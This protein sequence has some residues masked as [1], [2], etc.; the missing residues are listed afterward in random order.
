MFE[1]YECVCLKKD[2]WSTSN[3]KSLQLLESRLS[4]K[5]SQ[6]CFTEEPAYV[7]KLDLLERKLKLT[8]KLLA[9]TRSL[10][11]NAL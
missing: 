9:F 10:V 4:L 11:Q 6:Y 2:L 7:E 3:T 1:N 5:T 8:S